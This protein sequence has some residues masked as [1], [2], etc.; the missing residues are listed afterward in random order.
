MRSRYFAPV[1][2]L[3]L[4]KERIFHPRFYM[5]KNKLTPSLQT[6]KSMDFP[7]VVGGVL[8]WGALVLMVR[9]L[10]RLEKNKGERA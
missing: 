7:Y 6:E 5:P 10:Q 9:G 2:T 1:F 3:S 4:C 8:L